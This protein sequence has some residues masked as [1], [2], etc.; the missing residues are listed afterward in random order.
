MKQ[1]FKYNS[2]SFFLFSLVLVMA[3]YLPVN[4]LGF[5][6]FDDVDVV[7]RIHESF[8]NIPWYRLFVRSHTVQYY[9]PL[10]ELLCYLDY[11]LWGL[12]ITAWHLTNYIL[13]ILNALLVYQ[14][15][16]NFLQSG[17]HDR[18]WASFAMLL[19]ALNP[20]T[21]E[22][23]AWISGRS[24]LAGSFFALI[25]VWGYCWK[26][27]FRFIVVPAA[28]LAGLLCKE[29]ALAVIPIIVLI[30]IVRNYQHKRPFREAVKQCLFWGMIVLIPLF[31]YIYLRTS[32]FEHYF[33]KSAKAGASLMKNTAG[34]LKQSTNMTT[35]EIRDF[36]YLFP[37]IAFYFKKLFIPF[38]LN[39]AI[40][41]INTVLYSFLFFIISGINLVCAIRKR[42]TLPVFS[43]LLLLSFSPALIVALDKVA[44][45]PLAERYLYF[46]LSIMGI[47]M[48][49]FTRYFYENKFL[50]Q[51][52]LVVLCILIITLMSVT[53]FQREFAFKNSKA[54]WNATLKTNPDSSMVLCLYG[55]T[56]DK[57]E[58]KAAYQKAVS[59]PKP[60]KWR[61]KALINL[62]Q[63]EMADG[64]YQKA[65]LHIDNAL[66]M[67]DNYENYHNAAYILSTV[68]DQEQSVINHLRKKAIQCYKQAYS[69]K[70]T[71]FVLYRIATLLKLLGENDEATFFFN[72]ILKNYPE[73][74]YAGYSKKQLNKKIQ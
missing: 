18:I 2:S 51:K 8:S 54:I 45:V 43:L 21:C 67:E 61:A 47:S 74:K 6:N 48:A 4:Y 58:G 26:S 70:K 37:V 20:M 34:S 49:L 71:A 65:L 19:F 50:S 14:I 68:Q 40:E 64:N 62:A 33:Y 3:V 72:Q 73:S 29:N 10:L 30:A 63:Y 16:H 11:A 24:D 55:Q 7:N 69:R 59:N 35:Y 22:S 66:V 42:W 56:V 38:P 12:S 31:I 9:R 32:G 28:I 57:K 27:K 39:F 5:I 13:H 25:A 17:N 15:A 44:W 53:T 46:S 1:G 60:F 23:V 52:S 36:L 41:Q